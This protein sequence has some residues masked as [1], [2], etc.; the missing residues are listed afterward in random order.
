MKGTRDVK[1]KLIEACKDKEIFGYF[2]QFVNEH[3]DLEV[4]FRGGGSSNV[5]IVYRHGHVL[6]EFHLL[7][8]RNPVVRISI[9]HC[10]FMKNWDTFAVR[11]LMD[12]GFTPQ[13]KYKSIKKMTFED[14][15]DQNRL[16]SVTNQ[17]YDVIKLEYC[18]DNASNEEKI[19]KIVENSY[20]ILSKM[21]DVY[22]SEYEKDWVKVG[23]NKRPINY[24]KAMVKGVNPKDKKAVEDNKVYALPQVCREKH[25]QQ[26]LFTLNKNEDEGLFVYDL[27]FMQPSINNVKL[28]KN[29]KPDMLAVR[30]EKNKTGSRMV[31]IAFV[32]VKST[33]KA[34]IGRCGIYE[35]MLG[36]MSSISNDELMDDRRREAY[37]IRK[38]YCELGLRGL[39]PKD[40]DQTI[41]DYLNLPGEIIFIF[42]NGC[43]KNTTPREMIV[44]AVKDQDVFELLDIEDYSD[45]ISSGEECGE[46]K[47]YRIVLKKKS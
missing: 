39:S 31:S 27:E 1:D 47:A 35:H 11:G 17:G 23:D 30:Y 4:C 44:Q 41:N 3:D 45:K 32:E 21:M 19:K 6:W 28:P 5:V 46:T 10:R 38:R 37:Q 29:N 7:N 20:V 40:A 43:S 24:P 13:T 14:L 15:K 42:S 18:I 26:E 34:L 22:F 8:N 25:V 36:M 16:V 12:I 2:V 9:N 33:E